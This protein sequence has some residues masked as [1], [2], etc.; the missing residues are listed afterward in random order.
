MFRPPVTKR[1]ERCLVL[2]IAWLL[3]TPH[4]LETIPAINR[5]VRPREKGHLGGAS[6]IRADRWVELARPGRVAAIAAAVSA[7]SS[8]FISAA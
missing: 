8:T 2:G 3:L 5:F 6:T 4:G 1:N 7:V